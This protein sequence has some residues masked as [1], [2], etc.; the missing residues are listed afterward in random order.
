M[1]KASKLPIDT[2]ATAEDMA[3]AMFGSGINI[4][5]ASYSGAD[6]AS[7]IYSN[8]DDIA[9][10][11]TPSDSGVILSTGKAASIT[12]SGSN[13]NKFSFTSTNHRGEGDEDLTEMAGMQT[14]DAAVFEA[15]FVPEGSTLTM[16][17]TFASEEYLEYVDSGFNDAVGVFV[18][19][20]KAE[21][22]VGDGDITIDNIN[23]DTNSNLYVDNPASQDNYNTEMDGFTVTLT[24]KAPVQPGE[25]NT[26]KIGIADAGDGWYDSNLLI[27]GDSVQTAL[28]A[29]DDDV[30]VMSGETQMLDV[31]ANDASAA[32]GTLTVTHINNQP[33]NAGDS[34]TLATGEVIT[35]TKDG[36]FSIEGDGDDDSNLFSYTVADDSGNTDTAFVTVHSVACFVSGTLI[37]TVE[38]PRA[39]ETLGPGDRVLTRDHGPQ[40][41]RW[42]GQTQVPARGR[43]QPIFIAAGTFGDHGATELSPNHRVLVSSAQAELRFGA[44]EVLVPAKHLVDGVAVRPASPRQTV[45]YVH[46]LFDRHEVVFGNGLPSESY[47]PGDMTLD[48][49][50]ADARAELL[51]LFPDLARGGVGAYGPTARPVLR[52]YEARSLARAQLVGALL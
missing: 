49:F 46:L 43:F 15:S 47:H 24:L 37:D 1:T 31:L 29:D 52:A 34:V 36:Q 17:I 45:R 38:G 22:T 40:P 33:V 48:A 39:V 44:A 27:A 26:I 35:L 51:A 20:E 41:L 18:N 9:P 30:T 19:G 25:V 14:Y 2:D 32:G 8:G 5:S 28:V 21:L 12:N 16:Q 23:D 50:N 13:A 7:G 4:V 42:I 10:D 6:S 11:L 3:S